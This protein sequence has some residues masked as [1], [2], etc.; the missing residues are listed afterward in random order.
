MKS[1]KITLEFPVQLAD[2]VLDSVTFRRP[3][4]GDL[5]DCPIS[6]ESDVAGEVRLLSRLCGL[7]IEDM[8]AMDAA[9]YSKLQQQFLTFRLGK[10]GEKK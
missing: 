10:S 8:R 7:N 9:D 6:G 1:V 2:R 5:M 4:L 3:T